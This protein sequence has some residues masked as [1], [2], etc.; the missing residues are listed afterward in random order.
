LG[1]REISS[2]F[3]DY[4]IVLDAYREAAHPLPLDQRRLAGSQAKGPAV[5]GTDDL[6]ALDVSLAERSACVRAMT[7]EGVEPPTNAKQGDFTI[8]DLKLAAGSIRNLGNGAE[9]K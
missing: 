8:P 7:V 3:H 1:F 2:Q 5:P 9:Y 6:I 4:L